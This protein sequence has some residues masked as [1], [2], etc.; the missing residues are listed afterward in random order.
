MMETAKRVLKTARIEDPVHLEDPV[1]V[2]KRRQEE[3]QDI[4]RE[5]RQ[6]AERILAETFETIRRERETLKRESEQVLADLEARKSEIVTELQAEA[7]KRAQQ[8][9]EAELRPK[10]EAMAGSFE[11]LIR[12]AETVLNETLSENRNDLVDLALRVAE[13]VVGRITADDASLVERTV[14]K[15]LEAARD[16]QEMIIRVN[17]K[18]LEAVERFR[19]PL[20][21]RFDDLR[22]LQIEADGR[23]DRGGAWVETPTGFIDGR[24]RSQVEEMLSMVL[25]DA[26][27]PQTTKQGTT[28]LPDS[29]SPD[30]GAEMKTGE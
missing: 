9:V 17:P 28:L 11:S 3:A 24:I 19:I 21:E 15:V 23:V 25:P 16:R 18:D 2:E 30:A 22:K 26:E 14:T 1:Q 8:K 6:R 4:V 10:I 12:T 20:M 13:K 29:G 5:A 7:E 27:N